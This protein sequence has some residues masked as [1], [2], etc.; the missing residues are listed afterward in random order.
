M[1]SNYSWIKVSFSYK[2]KSQRDI[3]TMYLYQAHRRFGSCYFRYEITNIH[4]IGL[5]LFAFAACLQNIGFNLICLRKN[6]SQFFFNCLPVK[7]FAPTYY[8]GTRRNR[9]LLLFLYAKLHTWSWPFLLISSHEWDG[10]M[11]DK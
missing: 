6:I 3:G 11:I 2:F 4:V 9:L 10:K 8:L 7:D 1:P 5:S